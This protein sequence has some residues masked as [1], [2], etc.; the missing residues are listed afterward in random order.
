MHRLWQP[1]LFIY[2]NDSDSDSVAIFSFREGQLNGSIFRRISPVSKTYLLLRVLLC[3]SNIKKNASGSSFGVIVVSKETV[4]QPS[5]S[6]SLSSSDPVSEM[7]D[8]ES[9]GEW[10][11]KTWKSK[12]KTISGLHQTKTTK[13]RR[14]WIKDQTAFHLLPMMNSCKAHQPEPVF[15]KTR[16]QDPIQ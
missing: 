2:I 8:Q 13:Q 11:K 7:E 5:S 6:S 10:T 15:I 16:N 4:R 12:R 14:R 1:N 9:T 3:F